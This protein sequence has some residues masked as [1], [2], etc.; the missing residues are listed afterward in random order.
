MEAK[1]FFTYFRLAFLVI[2]SIYVFRFFVII[3][4]Y[5]LTNSIYVHH[6]VNLTDL[7]LS[8]Y[9]NL[10]VRNRS[11]HLQRLGQWFPNC[12]PR[13]PWEPQPPPKGATNYYNFSQF[14]LLFIILFQFADVD[15]L[16]SIIHLVPHAY[17]RRH[18]VLCV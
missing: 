17:L 14:Y 11:D 3:W 7:H 15:I 13:L 2:F 6:M 8:E 4:I 10:N 5:I 1:K 12:E 18:Y 9:E 16:Q